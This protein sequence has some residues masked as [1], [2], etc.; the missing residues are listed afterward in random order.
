ENQ[1]NVLTRAAL[2][3]TSISEL[4]N[5]YAPS[6]G[7]SRF[8]K[9]DRGGHFPPHRDQSFSYQVPDY[10]RIFVPLLNWT[11]NTL[12]FIVEDKVIQYEPGRAYFFNA[13]KVH[14]V[15]S[16][17]PEAVT[18]ALSVPLTQENVAKTLRA[19]EVN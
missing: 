1:F 7:R 4:L 5:H 16:T 10:F 12:F 11:P 9:F 3:L 19:F 17:V 14:T 18:L 15:F 2:E 8:V 6:L 13:M